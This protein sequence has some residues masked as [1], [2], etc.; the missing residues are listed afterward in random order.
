[1]DPSVSLPVQNPNPDKPDQKGPHRDNLELTLI[2]R[3]DAEVAKYKTFLLSADPAEYSGT[4]M[5][6]SKKMSISASSASLR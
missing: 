1:M 4:G 3:R 6:E 5:A 2:Y